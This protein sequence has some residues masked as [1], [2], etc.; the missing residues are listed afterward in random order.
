M[1]PPATRCR[2]MGLPIELDLPKGKF[3]LWPLLDISLSSVANYFVPVAV[4]HFCSERD[5]GSRVC[6]IF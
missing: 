2:F 1:M 5:L 4:D 6:I 3:V